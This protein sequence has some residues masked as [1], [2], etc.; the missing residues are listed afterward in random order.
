MA[1][2][3]DHGSHFGFCWLSEV[4]GVAVATPSGSTE[5]DRDPLIERVL[6]DS[7]VL[8]EVCTRL[9]KDPVLHIGRCTDGAVGLLLTALTENQDRPLLVLTSSPDAAQQLRQDVATFSARPIG[10]FPMWES[11]FEEDSEPDLDTFRDRIETMRDLESGQIKTVIAPVQAVLQPIGQETG[12]DHRVVLRVGDRRSRGDLARNLVEA[13]YRR[14]PQVAR[15]GDFAIR[16]SLFDVWPRESPTPY[17]IDFFD[18]EID[19]IQSISPRDQRVSGDLEL[20]VLS[21]A[22]RDSWFIR[23]WTG[24]QK[25][26]F[27]AL[28]KG[29]VVAVWNPKEVEERAHFLIGQWA[30]GHRQVLAES[31]WE[32]AG[33]HV[34]LQLDPLI[35]EG[36]HRPLQLPVVSA[37][38]YQGSLEGTVSALAEVSDRG[39]EVVVFL[40]QEAEGERFREVLS[41]S[42]VGPTVRVRM[43]QLSTG[44]RWHED[45]GGIFVS[46]NAAL[47]RK[48]SLEKKETRKRVEGRAVDNF[49]E[50]EEGQLVVHVTHGIA[51][52]QGLRAV[53]DGARQGDFLVLEFSEGVTLLV[54]VDRIDLVQKYIG[55]G[56]TA[57]KLDKVGGSLW[58]KKKA[59]AEE[60]VH[61]LA[62]ELLEVQAIRAERPG[63]P[64]P[65]DNVAVTAFDD[66]FPYDETGDQL[67]A[68]EAIKGDMEKPKPMDRLICGD[69]GYGKTELAMRAAFKAVQAG[70]QVAVLVPTTV[71]A[72]QHLVTFR[73]RMAEWPIQVES[74]SRFQGRRKQNEILEK[75]SK[76]EVD[77]LIGTHRLLSGDVHFED[78]GL[79]VI[80]EEQR[81]GVAHK[82]KLK[83][84]RRLVDVL[85]MTATP[86]PRTLHMSLVGV[87]DISS[88]HEAPEGRAPVQTEVTAFDERRFR[89]IGLR[90]INRDGQIYWLHN[91]VTSIQ[92]CK[93][94]VESLLPEAKVTVAHGQMD[95][96]EL[97]ERMVEFIDK[98]ANVLISTTIIESGLDIPSANTLIVERA[99]RFGLAQLHQ[100]RG[101][102]GRSHHKAYCY[103]VVPDDQ[104]IRPEARTRLQAIEEYSDLGSGFQIAM[105]D[106]EIRGAGNILGKEQS[107]HIGAVGYDLFCRLLERAVA[108]L[109]G[110]PA[111]EPPDVE[112]ALSGL[113]LIPDSYLPDTRQR[114]RHY[115]QIATALRSGQLDVI[116]EDLHDQ[117]GPVPTETLRLIGQQR[118]RITLGSWGVN[119]I[120]PEDGWI[121]L[122]GHRDGI[123]RGFRGLGWEIRP[124]PDGTIAGRP[125]GSMAPDDLD[126]VLAALGLLATS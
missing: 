59:R 86:I 37:D 54:P 110:T 78:L 67:H 1:F 15:P 125:P 14:F 76:G 6:N 84:L 106:L 60:S 46:G 74:I 99:D 36:G 113:C 23:G 89:Q 12:E 5:T 39:E 66:A 71:L 62:A 69:V 57:G 105:R 94:R 64:F 111:E 11:L 68:M 32:R 124:L 91:R 61:D 7:S 40:R 49:L 13:G 100:L 103:L 72:Q 20:V 122:R 108:H 118:L 30:S 95:E 115:R 79:I 56:R 80:D 48:R 35:P 117:F 109:R 120:S 29:S 82:E 70:K 97:E 43:G 75:V 31:F 121:I 42:N 81:F 22:P 114:L 33:R 21:L 3:T 85:T 4:S 9:K 34:R 28:P 2:R 55:G 101:R 47:G 8:G 51:R 93:N 44:F 53:R 26:L 87:K 107:G 16:G 92:E 102:V 25:L 17:R 116:T 90:E 24:T 104:P 38:R 73:E 65:E 119:R 77:I 27:D 88:L 126:G 52:Y 123:E 19:A 98:R 63:H 18:D 41:E 83:Q 96:L 50:L 10:D 45:G 112:M 58:S